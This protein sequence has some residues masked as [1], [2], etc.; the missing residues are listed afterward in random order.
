MLTESLNEYLRP[1][2]TKR[3]ELEQQPDYIR[4]VLKDGIAAA[5]AEAIATLEEVREVMNMML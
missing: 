5:R 4:R 1:H 3:K 2:R